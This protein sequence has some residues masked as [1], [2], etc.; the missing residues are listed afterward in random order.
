MSNKVAAASR[1]PT[2]LLT[3]NEIA[4]VMEND[5]EE[6]EE[7]GDGAG[8]TSRPSSPGLVKK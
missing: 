2:G 5:D 7:D 3:V 6:D 1:G 4:T 8:E